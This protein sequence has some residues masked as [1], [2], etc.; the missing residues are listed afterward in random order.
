MIKYLLE[1]KDGKKPK[2]AVFY[3]G[4]NDV[5]SANQNLKAGLPQ[6]EFK[7]RLEFNSLER[8]NWSRI[9]LNTYTMRIINKII[10]RN[11][12]LVGWLVVA[13]ESEKDRLIKDIAQTYSNNFRFVDNISQAQ[14]ISIYFFFQPSVYTK[15][16]R[17]ILEEQYYALYKNHLNDMAVYNEIVNI[18]ADE[19][20][21][22]RF[23]NI[24]NIYDNTNKTIFTDSIHKGKEGNEIEAEFMAEIIKQEL[25]KHNKNK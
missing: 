21:N 22:S 11:N 13:P 2:M 10:G 25:E 23:I 17:S 6:N 1:L 24:I 9:I 20:N 18:I 7:R 15:K 16:Q 5:F 3:T 14:N 4:F 12:N 19:L 8:N